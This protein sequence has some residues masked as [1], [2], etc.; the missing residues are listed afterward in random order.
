[1]PEPL[2]LD[3]LQDGQTTRE[4]IVLRLGPPSQTMEKESILFYRLGEEKSGHFIREP[5]DQWYGVRSS[6]VLVLDEKGVLQKH[7]LVKVR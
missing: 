4:E 5:H 7:S 3:F 1:M 6:L 2:K